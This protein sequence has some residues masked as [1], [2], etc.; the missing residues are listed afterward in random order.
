VAG[1]GAAFAQGAATS[2]EKPRTP[3]RIERGPAA[4]GPDEP[5]AKPPTS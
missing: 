4:R 3:P 1:L 5:P 2:E